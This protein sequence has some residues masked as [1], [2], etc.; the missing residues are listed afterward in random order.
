MTGAPLDPDGRGA[1]G[2]NGAVAAAT[3]EASR[4]GVEILR[5][6]GNAVD[7]AVAAAFAN[8]VLEPN[9]NG[10]GGGGFMLI[11]LAG[12]APVAIDFRCAA[13]GRSSPAMFQDAGRALSTEGGL[14][15]AVPGTPAGLLFALERFGS[16]RLTR[17]E[18][19]QPAID[20]AARGVP[21]S[22]NLA[23][24]IRETAG[25]LRRCPASS[26][27][28]LPGGA[29]P[30]AVLANPD[31]A[32]T[33]RLIA[34][35]GRDAFYLGR[36]AERIV[37]GIRDAGGIMT[38][39]DLSGYAPRLRQP[40]AG[41]YR[42]HALFSA[43]PA[44]SGGTH[45]IELLQILEAFD[46]G[47]T[48][49]APAAH[50]WAEA[51]KLVLADRAAHMGD[52]DFVPVPLA[53]LTS[54]AHARELAARIAPGGAGLPGG[55]DPPGGTARHGSGSTTHLSV[56]D[57][58]G[59]MVALTQ[60]LNDFFGCGVTIA[61]TGITLNDDMD[62]FEPRPGSPNSIEPGKRPLSSMSPT[63]VLDPMGRAFLSIGSPGGLRIFASTAQVISGIL[64]SG[65][66]VGA[67]INAPRLFQ[68]QDGP[69]ELE[70][71][72]PGAVRAGLRRM[73]HR[74]AVRED[75]DIYF[76]GAQAVLYDHGEGLLVGGADPRRDG[77][78][79]AF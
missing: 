1:S 9:A 56:M 45:L 47:R 30:E 71:R 53:R 57:R 33:L 25:K 15:A 6:G 75:W 26:A 17:A 23:W 50:L 44:S 49:G 31:G 63:L 7:A 39:E 37:D 58:A 13:P 60:T 34:A 29:P 27:I 10:L 11:R 40:V 54:K 78:A 3:A 36:V 19:M 35:E 16:G 69:L 73:G 4:I 21:V 61:G 42:G 67:A 8:G 51:L 76:G 46:L 59:N 64:D 52:S 66:P 2:R 28:Y 38:L 65:L 24:H 5:R 79:A 32:G 41:S 18:I 68:D 77:Q 72:V 62:D 48:G 43:P 70:G 55:A 22:A 20:W 12:S 74:L 14:A